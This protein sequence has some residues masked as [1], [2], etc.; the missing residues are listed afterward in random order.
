MINYRAESITFEHV[1]LVMK[2]LGKL[3]AI[4]FALKDQ[5]PE[6]F[7]ELA[8]LSFEQYWTFLESEFNGHY[9]DTL[10]RLTT[11]LE[12]EKRLDLLEKFM[13]VAGEDQCTTIF[14]LVSSVAA[15]PY[16]IICHGD[17][18]TNNSMFRYDQEGK[19]LA[20]QLI[21]WQFTRYASPVTDL[22][23]YLF[24]STSKELRDDYYEDFLNIYHESLCDL[25]M[26]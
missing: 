13:R 9:F 10:K 5:Q 25:L 4:S 24:C 1:S 3:H 23:L 12:E 6:K 22:V 16:A 20:V 8:S 7:K 14:N 19:A 21:D 2:A 15:E 18:T 11:I 17:L 26:R